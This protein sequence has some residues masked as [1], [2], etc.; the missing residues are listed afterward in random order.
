MHLVAPLVA[1]IKGAENGT[2]EIYGRDTLARAVYW[3]DFEGTSAIVTGLDVA[4]D[5]H[6]GA[7]VYVDELCDVVVKTSGGAVLR[8]FVAGVAAT[9]TEVVSQSFHGTDYTSGLSGLS[10]PTTLDQVLDLWLT[11]NGGT[12]WQI[13]IP[14]SG[15]T[16]PGIGIGQA[17]A[18]SYGLVQNVR[19][20][21]AAGDGVIDDTSAI[22]AAISAAVA[23]GGGIVYFPPGV[24]RTA[25]NHTLP[26]IV[27]LLGAGTSATGVVLDGLGANRVFQLGLAASPDRFNLIA[28][29]HFRAAVLAPSATIFDISSSGCRS[30]LYNLALD[31]TNF[32]GG[33]MTATNS[34]VTEFFCV[35]CV[36][37]LNSGGRALTGSASGHLKRGAFRDCRFITPVSYTAASILLCADLDL[38][39]C[40]FDSA[41]T[42]TGTYSCLDRNT[43]TFTWRVAGCQFLDSA[44]AAVTAMTMGTYGAA[45]SI[46]ESD[47]VF[48]AAVTA[49]VYTASAAARGSQVSLRS[50]EMRSIFVTN[51]T[52]T[53]AL[54]V[55][56]YGMVVLSSTFAG[57]ITFSAVG[58]PPDGARGTIVVAH[59]AASTVIAGTNF[60]NPT[61]TTT[62]TGAGHIWEYRACTPASAV[63]MALTVDGR[64]LG[65]TL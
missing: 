65:A 30:I 63:R 57:L 27:S 37:R 4:L 14:G 6:G 2:A 33:N 28:N 34:T 50:R 29:M 32:G 58:V 38:D 1:G 19:A 3:L 52:A 13:A 10:E 49:Y 8:S 22:N 56:Q 31:G 21:G 39:G 59:P 17:I 5:S 61:A 12:D 64:S 54:P 42:T 36:F 62:A 20:F 43:S 16:A 23:A 9:V 47:N 24:Y 15:I 55:D 46:V 60:L 41:A 26:G 53:P 51:N 25:G 7:A 48:G 35:D 44:G 40:V 45:A 18:G 11:I